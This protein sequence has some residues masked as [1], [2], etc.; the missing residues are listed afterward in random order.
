MSRAA[1]LYGNEA[2]LSKYNKLV[3]EKLNEKSSKAKGNCS[4]TV[5]ANRGL[6][7]MN[8]DIQTYDPF[9]SYVG[10]HSTTGAYFH[11]KSQF[12]RLISLLLSDLGMIFDIRCPSP[13]QIISELLTRGIIS[14]SESLDM[15]ECLSFANEIRLR[16]YFANNGQKE[17]ISPI[18]EYTKSTKPSINAAVFQ[19]VDQDILVAFLCTSNDVF[20]RCQEFS[21]IRLSKNKIDRSI[22]RCIPASFS[23]AWLLGLHYYRLQNYHEA[24]EWLKAESKYGPYYLDSLVTQGTIYLK[25][26]KY[27][28]CIECYK[29]ALKLGFQSVFVP[30]LYHNLAKA[31]FKLGRNKMAILRSKEVIYYHNEIFSKKSQSLIP[32]DS[33]ITLASAYSC[34][35]ELELAVKTLKEAQEVQKE[36]ENVPDMSVILLNLQMADV[37]SKLNQYDQSIEYIEKGLALSYQLFGECRVIRGKMRQW[38]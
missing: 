36:L 3:N 16:T 29:E 27:G 34:L 10:V 23:N 4:E 38:D 17:L 15:R 35:G 22:F 20:R 28:K 14:M 12:Y 7:Q 8:L 24:L 1:L 26:G 5:G 31:L 37:L 6:Q 33:R 21:K 13:W 30:Q 19:D 11:A 18:P 2:L 32:L 9:K 25:L